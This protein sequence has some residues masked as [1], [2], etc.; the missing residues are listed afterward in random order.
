SCAMSNA[1]RSTSSR[2]TAL[3]SGCCSSRWLP[4]TCCGWMPPEL[5]RVAELPSTMEAAH[6]LAQ[7][8]AAHGTA[9][10]A[11]R[12]TLGRGTRGRTW[13]SE[14]GGLWLSVIA[15]PSRTDALE[16]LSLRVG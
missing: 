14:L 6:A 9:V 16:A 10:V 4:C 5:I 8:G 1:I 13:S 11:A 3:A 7:D 15:R 12:Q 2:G